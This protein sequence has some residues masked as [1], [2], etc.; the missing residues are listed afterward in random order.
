M[1]ASARASLSL[2]P[3]ALALAVALALAPRAYAQ[4]LPTATT[5]EAAPESEL[6]AP[7]FSLDDSDDPERLEDLTRTF[8]TVD[9]GLIY[10]NEDSAKFGRYNGLDKS[11]LLPALGFQLRHRGAFDGDDASYWT[12]TA[13]NLGLDSRQASFEYGVQGSY[14]LSLDYQQIPNRRSDS[15]RTIFDGAG[16]DTLTLPAGWVGATTTAGMTQ[17][18]PS[19]KDFDLGTERKRTTLG[20]SGVLTPRWNYSTSVRRETKQG[21]KSIGGVFGN[22]GGNPRAA[23]LPEPVDYTTDEVDAVLRYGGRGFQ[24]QAAYYLS[25]FSNDNSALTW[26]NPFTTISGW[27]SSTGFPNGIGQ[28]SLPPD[29]RFQQFVVDTSYD[30]S[31]STRVNASVSKG[32]MTQDEDFLP[33]SAI[34]ALQA[35]VTQALPR[36]SLDGRIDTTVANFRIASRPTQDFS[37][38]FSWRYDDRDNRTPRDEYVYIGG[39]SQLQDTSVASSRRRYN[40]PYSYREEV[41]RFDAAYRVAGN[42]RLGLA[43][44]RSDVD[45]TY[46]EREKAR[47]DSFTLSIDSQFAERFDAHVRYSAANRDGSTYVGTEP[48]FSGYSPGYTATIVAGWENH[49]AL[50]R[51]FEADRNR[52]QLNAMLQFAATDTLSLGANIDWARD[53]YDASEVGLLDA[54]TRSYTFDASYTPAGLWSAYGFYSYEAQGSHQVGVSFSNGANQAPQAADPRRA[55]FVHHRDRMD[56]VGLGF[57]RG[58]ASG[59]FE[60]GA[61][62]VHARTW[63]G[64][65]FAVGS[66]LSTKPLPRDQTRL[67]SINLHSTWR[68]Q[69]NLSLTLGYWLERYKS[70]DWALD[71]ILP[72]TLA[73][74]ILL[75]E[76]SP[77]YHVQVLTLTATYR[78]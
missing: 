17:L 43:L 1:N 50:R 26:A 23:L 36:S 61:D 30:F 40:E 67:S 70:S 39:D 77:D 37:W 69:R 25:V 18:L 78:F 21:T 13:R 33:Y 65:D 3:A 19:L 74:V 71:G 58:M 14:R 47:E 20:L 51:F 49:P 44:Q 52:R 2:Q 35:S 8:S 59:K 56:V 10:V 54:D 73:N 42:T 27:T 7:L 41:L 75:G 34:P 11:G 68:L 45:R 38:N 63:S 76:T 29:N 64:M 31:G 62:F 53:E 55:W 15:T 46:L 24:F 66:L 22:S 48:F 16:S 12:A 72:N 5:T 6:S 60:F 9:F 28:L 32:R 57:K 4:S